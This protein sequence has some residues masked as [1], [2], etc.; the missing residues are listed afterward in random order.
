M[1]TTGRVRDGDAIRNLNIRT[2]RIF[3]LINGRW[4]E[5]HHDRWIIKTRSSLVT[6]RMRCDLDPHKLDSSHDGGRTQGSREATMQQI[7]DWLKMLGMSEYAE[8][9]AANHIDP[10]C[11]VI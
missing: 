3:Q 4:R 1:V 9:F 8:C 2:T 6:I 10:L 11:S 7:A 5:T